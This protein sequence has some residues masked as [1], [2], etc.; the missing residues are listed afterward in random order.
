MDEKY[1]P[2]CVDLLMLATNDARYWLHE[3]EGSQCDDDGCPLREIAKRL[4]SGK[5]EQRESGHS[6][7][8]SLDFILGILD[9]SVLRFG[10]WLISSFGALLIREC[11]RRGSLLSVTT[12]LLWAAKRRL[13]DRLPRS[14]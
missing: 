2:R 7:A 13:R 14:A 6:C 9:S 10:I 11:G 8:S 4:S 12:T 1:C 3:S 5:S